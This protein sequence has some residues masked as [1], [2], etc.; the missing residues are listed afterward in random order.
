MSDSPVGKTHIGLAY[1]KTTE[2]ESTTAGDYTWALI[3]GEQ[4]IQ[5]P[6]GDT[7]YTWI[8]NADTPTTGIS[9]D[10]SGKKYM[11]IAYNKTSATESTTYGD[12]S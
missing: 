4:G 11:C 5:G 3:Q 12:Y 9:D 2:T 1:N 8:K 7:L 10:P 6:D